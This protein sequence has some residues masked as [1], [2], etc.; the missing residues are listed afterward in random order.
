MSTIAE[1]ISGN[2]PET[3]QALASMVPQHAERWKGRVVPLVP[4]SVQVE[5]VAGKLA[6]AF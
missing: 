2:Q 6:A 5:P 1:I 3:Y 4:K